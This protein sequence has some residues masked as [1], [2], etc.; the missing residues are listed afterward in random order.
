MLAVIALLV[1]TA[2]VVPLH[3]SIQLVNNSTRLILFFKHIKWK[4]MLFF[5]IGILPG[6]VC[7]IFI[8]KMLDAN[9]VKLLMGVFILAITYMPKSK[10]QTAVSYALFLPV[11]FVSG[12]IG[13][14]FGAIGPFIAPFFLRK[15]VIK[16]ELVAT[17]AAC[18]AISHI[19][20]IP[21]FGFIGINVFTA[22][23]LFVCLSLTVI[24]G[25][26]IGKRL[27]NKISDDM[28]RKI[29]KI[30]LT[31]IGLK[32]VLTQIIHYITIV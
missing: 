26:I 20:K 16:E 4:I 3:A 10:K 2:Y 17:K 1:D 25:T 14:F 23:P 7:G 15:D 13:I 11:G 30:L 19:I 18:Q 5:V 21:L 6:A 22:W 9:L 27:L 8:F 32:I 12:F 29:F 28:F 24:V 31:I